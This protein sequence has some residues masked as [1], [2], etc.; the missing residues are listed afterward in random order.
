MAIII[1]FQGKIS[2]LALLGLE[3]AERQISV[4]EDIR[5]EVEKA[6]HELKEFWLDIDVKCIYE[7]EPETGVATSTTWLPFLDNYIQVKLPIR[8]LLYLGSS[9]LVK[10]LI[11]QRELINQVEDEVAEAVGLLIDLLGIDLEKFYQDLQEII[12]KEQE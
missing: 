11:K 10:F 7:Y 2:D 4:P 3:A 1:N 6:T 12:E 9:L 8:D 5:K